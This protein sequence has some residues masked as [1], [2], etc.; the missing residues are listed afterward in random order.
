MTIGGK[1]VR[2]R[3]RKVSKKEQKGRK[4]DEIVNS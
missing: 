4:S 2:R 3:E 1:K